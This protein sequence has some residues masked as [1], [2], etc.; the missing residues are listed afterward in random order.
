MREIVELSHRATPVYVEQN[1]LFVNG[2][3]IILR[4]LNV[5]E[6]FKRPGRDSL[7]TYFG[8]ITEADF[9]WMREEWG[10][11]FA[12]MIFEWYPFEPEEGRWDNAYLENFARRVTWAA[13]NGIYVLIDM[14]QDLYGRGF[15]G[16]GAPEWT[17]NSIHYINARKYWLPRW[18][19]NYFQGDVIA[20]F[21]HF[22]NSRDYLWKEFG[23]TWR[24]VAHRFKD[25]QNV[26][27]FEILNEPFPGSYGP[28]EFEKNIL[29]PFYLYVGKIIR[30]TAPDKLLFFE[31]S[32]MRGAGLTSSLPPLP[33]DQIVY[34]PHYY[35]PFI[36]EG[37]QYGTSHKGF[38][39]GIIQDRLNEAK[40]QKAAMILGEY[41]GWGPDY[42]ST[43]RYID[44]LMD[45]VDQFNL[46][47][48]YWD[49]DFLKD[50]FSQFPQDFI[51]S[52]ARAYPEMW[53]G[54]ARFK[55]DY[56]IPE[57]TIR[58]RASKGSK[59]IVA[60]PYL[61]FRHQV[62]V[63]TDEG[64]IWKWKNSFEMEFTLE[65]NGEFTI[66]ITKS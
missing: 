33:F 25:T 3:H 50:H 5:A 30:E 35:D 34:A 36:H 22:W 23:E 64:V 65:M 45:V 9:R 40:Y 46:G 11:N 44:D 61:T 42:S 48:A 47:A 43:A 51:F 8:S 1:Q 52:L 38:Y 37:G 20:C 15:G 12:R 2:F 7:D 49:I 57:I 54:E 53:I 58:W 19:L 41:G 26:I 32:I 14:H 63:K 29:Y 31:P 56:T 66:T 27:G 62:E 60:L 39:Y 55:Y 16:N 10:F 4:G 59:M 24:R 21:D 18:W 17:C 6:S 13:E 28:C